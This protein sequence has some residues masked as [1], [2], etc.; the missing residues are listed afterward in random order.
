MKIVV[1]GAT[2]TIGAA[3]VRALAKRHEV[4][5]VSRHTEPRVDLEDPV[6]IARLFSMQ[7]GID[8]V[9]SCAGNAAFKPLAQL[10]DEDFAFSLRNKLMGQV[11]VVRTA[12]EH[13]KDGGSIT[14]TSGLLAQHPMVGGAAISMVNA[15]LEGFVRSAALEATR[16][17]RINVVSP[18]WVK[19]T[20]LKLQMDPSPG[21][22]AEDVAKAYV[23]AIEGKHHGEVLDPAR[24]L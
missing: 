19:E 3:V 2:G 22:A 16:G 9:V 20:L 17:I 11:S 14:V 24:F 13:V 23:E 7:S 1:I 6:S 12:M 4:I 5:G 18:P 15:G 21:L 10:T 8:A